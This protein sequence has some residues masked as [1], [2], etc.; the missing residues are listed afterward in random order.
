MKSGWL[1]YFVVMVDKGY[2][3]LVVIMEIID[4]FID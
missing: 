2:E 3:V 1:V 4:Y